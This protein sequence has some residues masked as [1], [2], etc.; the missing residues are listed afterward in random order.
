MAAQTQ[1][2]T[3]II[4]NASNPDEIRSAEAKIQ[5]MA[6]DMGTLKDLL[7][8]DFNSN[9]L[10]DLIN[11]FTHKAIV[12]EHANPKSGYEG[13]AV[14][15]CTG[16]RRG[17]SSKGENMVEADIKLHSINTFHTSEDQEFQ[18]RVIS[19]IVSGKLHSLSGSFLY[20]GTDKKD[21]RGDV[22]AQKR[23]SNARLRHLSFTD[24]PGSPV[25]RLSSVVF[26]SKAKRT[27]F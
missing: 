18:A 27:P 14:G 3:I 10:Q 24:N 7:Q 5:G 8:D 6:V 19:D 23:G 11:T 17:K 22:I 16:A 9:S 4:R 1:S 15:V 13:K 2:G 20:N 26:S 21:A 25:D 12:V